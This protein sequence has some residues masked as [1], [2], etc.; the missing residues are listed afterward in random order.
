MRKVDKE[1]SYSYAL[2]D[3]ELLS[4]TLKKILKPA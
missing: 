3:K 1:N 4:S 2:I